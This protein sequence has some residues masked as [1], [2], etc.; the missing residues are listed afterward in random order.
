MDTTRKRTWFHQSFLFNT[1]ANGKDALG[2]KLDGMMGCALLR[3]HAGPLSNTMNTGGLY[4]KEVHKKPQRHLLE[5][6]HGCRTFR[7]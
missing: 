2:S 4:V 6:L 1:A 3:N 7:T 5:A